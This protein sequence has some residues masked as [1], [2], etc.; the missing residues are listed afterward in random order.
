MQKVDAVISESETNDIETAPQVE[1][2]ENPNVWV[3][4]ISGNRLLVQYC[5]LLLVDGEIVVEIDD[6][7]IETELKFRDNALIM[8]VA[9]NII[10]TNAVKNFIMIVW[11][12]VGSPDLYYNKKCY[13][14]IPLRSSKDKD[15]VLMGGPYTIF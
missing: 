7:D 6:E 1:P 15:L 12:F 5:P 13:F 4:V 3:D 9:K 8:L 2:A 14:I 10:S 11:N